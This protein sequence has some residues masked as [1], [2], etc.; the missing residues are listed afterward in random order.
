LGPQQQQFTPHFPQQQFQLL[1]QP[2]LLA[3]P[4]TNLNNKETQPTYNIEFSIF[5]A[6]VLSPIEFQDIHFRLGR[7]INNQTSLIIT[8][9]DVE[10]AQ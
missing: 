9:N 10:E 3:Q 7:V 6:F 5:P 2:Q 1:Q 8:Q 4:A